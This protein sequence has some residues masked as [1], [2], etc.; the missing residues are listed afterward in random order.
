MIFAFQDGRRFSDRYKKIRYVEVGVVETK[1][2]GAKIRDV[3]CHFNETAPPS[4]SLDQSPKRIK[5]LFYIYKVKTL[6]IA[7]G[8]RRGVCTPLFESP[9]NRIP[10]LWIIPDGVLN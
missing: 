9:P 5:E 10:N 1:E 8:S 3:T 2:K 7:P 4:R 6:S